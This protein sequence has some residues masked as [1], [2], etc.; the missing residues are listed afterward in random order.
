M[1]SK[2]PKYTEVPNA[3]LDDLLHLMGDAELRVT[4][5]VARQTAGY[6]R[7]KHAISL[8][9]FEDKTGLSRQGVLN[10][11]SAALKRGTIERTEGGKR[12]AF[13]YTLHITNTPV[14]SQ[15]SGLVNAVD[16]SSELTSQDSRLVNAVDPTSQPSRLEVVNEVDLD[17]R[18]L[19]KEK[20]R[21]KKEKNNTSFQSVESDEQDK[22]PTAQ[23][24]L[25]GAV[26]EAIGWDYRTLSKEDTGQIAQLCGVLAKNDY[27]AADV[28]RFMSDIWAHDWRAKDKDRPQRPS[29]KQL[30]QEIGKLRSTSF[31]NGANSNGSNS[32]SSSANY[33]RPEV[34]SVST[35]ERIAYNEARIAAGRPY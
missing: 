24:A 25:F 16:Q 29:L 10:G 21:L 20:E 9:D 2:K 30:R 12:G 7:T 27:S 5:W 1:S 23:Q 33:R 26:C 18:V 32:S 31:L 6:H 15:P 4:L 28:Q 8:K 17:T 22:L 14:T 35:A 3:M 34:S 11:I 13:F 19:K